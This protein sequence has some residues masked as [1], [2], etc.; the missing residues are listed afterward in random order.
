MSETPSDAEILRAVRRVHDLERRH[1]AL[2]ARLDGMAEARSPEDVAEQNRYGEAMAA[3][4][5]TL[6][7]E[8]VFALE[9]IGLSLAARAVEVTAAAEGI[10]LPGAP[11][12]GPAAPGARAPDTAVH[13]G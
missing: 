6:L 11:S 10:N 12:P 8:S 1:E 9:E 5:E 3:T 4:A 7:I 13:R 2:R